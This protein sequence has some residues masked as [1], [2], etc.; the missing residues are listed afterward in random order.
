MESANEKG[1]EILFMGPVIHT[2]E[3]RQRVIQGLQARFNLSRE[4]A[5]RLVQRAPIV[6]KRGVTEKESERY[7]E[8][9]HSI[10]AMVRVR[11]YLRSNDITREDG[12]MPYRPGE[13]EKYCPW[14][15]LEEL[16]FFEALLTTLKEVLLSPTQF[17]RRMPTRG[18]FKH[19]LIFGLILG[20]LGGVLGLAWQRVFMLRIGQSPGI[21]TTHLV[22]I[23]IG[24]PLIVL[25]TLYLGSAIIHLCLMVVGGNRRGFEATFRVVAYS[26]STQIFALIP[27]VGG[28]VIP[29]YALAIEIIGLKEGHGI[30]AGRA[31]LAVFLPF[32]A[33]AAFF[34]LVAISLLYKLS[35]LL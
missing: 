33:M 15:D 29:I 9:F 23:T 21:T 24:L 27:F 6:I 14:E 16:G 11:E 30:G 32:I 1:Y 34:V 5:I 22:G 13:E 17:Y 8:A 2:A 7:V 26:W 18:G 31:V 10:G 19:P 12:T 4:R 3:E 20:V 25:V 35:E 28:L